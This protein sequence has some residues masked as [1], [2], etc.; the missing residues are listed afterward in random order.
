[1][2]VC[3]AGKNNIAIEVTEYL[4]SLNYDLEIGIVCNKN[5]KDYNSWQRSFRLYARNNNIKEYMLED[6]YN[7]EDVLFLSM[8]FD[9]IIRP[10]KFKNARLFNIHFSLLP[11][12]KGMYTS[13]LPI[14]NGEKEVGVTFHKIDSG[15][16]TGEIISQKKFLLKDMTS[17]ELY[18]SYIKYGTELVIKNMEDILQKK[19]KSF[20][21]NKCGSTYYSK[22]TIDYSNLQL[23]LNKTAEEIHRQIRAFNFRDYQMPTVNGVAY[24]SDYIT[25]IKS[26][27][28]PGTIISENDISI[29][30]ST[31]DYNIVLYKDRF[32][33]LMEACEKGN[34]DLVKDICSVKEHVN[35]KNNKGWTPL[36]VATYNNH[37]DIVNYL[38][39]I[40]ADIYVKNNNGTNLLMYAKDVYLNFHDNALYK[41]YKEYG[42]NEYDTDYEDKDLFYYM[43]EDNITLDELVN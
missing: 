19:E 18:L 43:K 17:K 13:A 20:P 42:L 21:Q 30:M 3:V 23:D 33:L 37:K 25:D 38:I 16:D 35:E 27:K 7:K 11:A 5:E 24:I 36:I 10:E 28:K 40:G 32:D 1:M 22:K 39:G 4:R 34:Y 12:Y 29:M 15:I 9:R 2:F 26:I 8:E 6:I 41:L 14:L 31:I